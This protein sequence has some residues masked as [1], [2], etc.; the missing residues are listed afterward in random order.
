MGLF[1]ERKEY[2]GNAI[3]EKPSP[4]VYWGTLQS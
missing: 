1:D 4:R 2:P 3:A